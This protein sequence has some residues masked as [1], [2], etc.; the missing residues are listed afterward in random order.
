MRAKC[1]LQS[2]TQQQLNA[3]HLACACFSHVLMPICTAH[4]KPNVRVH[5]R[6]ADSSLLYFCSCTTVVTSIVLSLNYE[7]MPHSY[8]Q[9]VG[10]A[11]H[12]QMQVDVIEF[13]FHNA[14]VTQCT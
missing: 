1:C 7:A 6:A 4:S 2:R 3:I 11:F 5:N 8:T 13:L 12:M 9:T 10:L 14:Y